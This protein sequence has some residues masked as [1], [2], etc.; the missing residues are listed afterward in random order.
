MR[1]AFHLIDLSKPKDKQH[2][3]CK[4]SKDPKVQP[5][6]LTLPRTLP[7]THCSYPLNVQ[8]LSSQ[9]NA[10]THIDKVQHD[11]IFGPLF[12]RRR[13]LPLISWMW[14]CRRSRNCSRMS[15]ISLILQRRWI[16]SRPL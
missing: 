15:S 12:V 14:R 16:L 8:S 6:P 10:Y 11:T 7:P 1:A 4:M 5:M 2:Y 13:T 9:R 3:V